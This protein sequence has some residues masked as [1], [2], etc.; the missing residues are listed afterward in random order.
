MTRPQTTG[1]DAG[2]KM[3]DPATER[4]LTAYARLNKFLQN[5]I[6]HVRY[7]IYVRV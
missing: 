1:P 6:D 2:L 3:L 7:R 5:F 4:S